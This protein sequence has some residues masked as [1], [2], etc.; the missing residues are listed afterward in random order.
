[1]NKN[2]FFRGPERRTYYDMNPWYLK[3]Q[4]KEIN[5]WHQQIKEVNDFLLK[6]IKS[7]IKKDNI[8]RVLDIAC[9]GG[10]FTLK[11]AGSDFSI[12]AFEYSSIAVEMAKNKDNFFKVNFF[13]GDA[14]NPASYKDNYYDLIIAKDFLHC[15]IGEDRN[16]F[17]TLVNRSLNS[18]GTFLFSTHGNLPEKY[19]L[20][21]N[22]NSLLQ[23]FLWQL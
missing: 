19:Y 15:L 12:D 16:N 4:E 9:G 1:M 8:K 6:E 22:L 3:N 20:F 18:N 14:L 21:Y 13:E 2:E 10:D 11:Y 17:F 5:D 7:L 23:V